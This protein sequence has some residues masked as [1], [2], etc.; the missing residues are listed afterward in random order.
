MKIY[1]YP[2]KNNLGDKII[3]SYDDTKLAIDKGES[4]IHTYS[5]ANF[6]MDLIDKGYRIYLVSKNLRF[7]RIQE[8][9]YELN[10]DLR[11]SHN[12]LKMFLAGVFNDLLENG[13]Y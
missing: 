5:M 6:S 12:I 8:H 13:I 9:M 7:I 4:I 2:Y 10:K 3:E 11:K 1:F